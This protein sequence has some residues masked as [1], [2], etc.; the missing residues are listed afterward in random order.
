MNRQVLTPIILIVALLG[1]CESSEPISRQDGFAPVDGGR[2]YYQFA[3]SGD[4]VVLVHGIAGDHRH[5]NK[6]FEQIASRFKV[7]RYDVRGWGQSSN[8]VIG[9]PY[10][11][12]SDLAKLLDHIGVEK[13]HIVG[14]SM[15]SGIAFDF[16][17]A[18]PNRAKSLVS[19]GPWVFG[20]RS[21]TIDKLYEKVGAVAD[22]VAWGGAAAGANAFVDSVLDGS[23]LDESADEFVRG[24]G[25]ESSFWTFV[26]PRQS[27]SLN[28]S[29]ATQLSHLTIPILVI[30][31]EHDLPA[32]REM[33][34]FIVTNAPNSRQFVV[35]NSGHLMHIE[36]P[37]E[38]NRELLSFLEDL[39]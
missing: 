28:P 24:V 16:A 3:G 14:W 36:K 27:V 18:Y 8:P 25:A 4:T 12:F 31:A 26:N 34:D 35:Q 15:G 21:E 22:A 7:I 17:T 10:S 6:Q 29:A 38:F 5:W 2:L 32:C 33:G 37:D 9:S 13:A 30:T 23:I 11:D 1:G 19:V 20:H 39:R